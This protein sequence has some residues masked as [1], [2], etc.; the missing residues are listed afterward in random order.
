M[1][2]EVNRTL[3]RL[4]FVARLTASA[5]AIHARM[6]ADAA[7]AGQRPNLTAAGGLA[8][9]EELLAAREA[10]YREVATVTVP[11]DGRSPAEVAGDIV[12]GYSAWKPPFER[13]F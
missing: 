13:P 5:A 2:R 11:T 7:T 8:E 10:L 3:L 9:V 4:G 1:L 12:A 6:A